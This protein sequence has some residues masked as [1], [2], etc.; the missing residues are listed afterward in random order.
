MPL[1][2]RLNFF[3]HCTK[4]AGIFTQLQQW[5]ERF[6]RLVGGHR[7]AVEFGKHLV[8]RGLRRIDPPGED[9]FGFRRMVRCPKCWQRL[10][11]WSVV[12][13][14]GMLAVQAPSGVLLQAEGAGTTGSAE[15]FA[16]APC[17]KAEPCGPFLSTVVVAEA[18]CRLRVSSIMF[19][20]STITGRLHFKHGRILAVVRHQLLVSSFFYQFAAWPA[21]RCGRP[22]EP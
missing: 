22:C 17:S 16:S 4:Q 13:L 21:P 15:P 2:Q 10:L 20:F 11:R 3:E 14:R 1:A 19:F 12:I 6:A 5:I 8:E 18:A 9:V 7:P